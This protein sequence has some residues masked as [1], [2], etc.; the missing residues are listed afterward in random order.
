MNLGFYN[1]FRW[2]KIPENENPE[3]EGYLVQYPDGYISWSPKEVFEEA[4]RENGQM[5]F[6][7]ALEFLKQGKRVCRSGWNDKI[8]VFMRSPDNEKYAEVQIQLPASLYLYANGKIISEWTC[9]QENM[10]AE[11]WMVLD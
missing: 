8:F 6:G 11:D 4:Y 9:S 7:H 1:Q 5:N 2:W 10:F 3:R